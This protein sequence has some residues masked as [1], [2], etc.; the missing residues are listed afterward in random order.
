MREVFSDECLVLLLILYHLHETHC[1]FI[2]V[3]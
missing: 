1:G 2:V 3:Q